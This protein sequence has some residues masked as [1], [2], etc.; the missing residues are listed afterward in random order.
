MEIKDRVDRWRRSLQTKSTLAIIITAAVL[1]EA[2]SAVQY[3]FA[4]KGIREEIERRAQTELQVKNLEIQKVMASVES[5]VGNMVWAVEERLKQSDSIPV[6]ADRLVRHNPSIVGCGIA[7]VPDYYKR[8]GRWYE[9][10]AFQVDSTKTV[11]SQ[12][13]GENHDYLQAKWFQDALAAGRGYWSDPYFDDAGAKMMLCTYSL[14]VRDEKGDIVAILGADVSL[15]WLGSVINANPIYP[16]AFNLMISREGQIMACPV[17]TLVLNKTIQELTGT[18][19][20]TTVLRINREMLE[21][22]SGQAVVKDE[23]GE[24][25]YVFYAPVEGDTGWSMAIICSDR[26]IYR[27]LRQVGFNLMLLMLLGLAL[28]M[29]ILFRAIRGFNRLQAVNAQKASMENELK[30]ASGI[31]MAMLPKIFPP[32]PDRDELDIYGSLAAAKGVGGDLFDFYIRDEKLFFCIGDVSGKGIPASLVM[33]VTRAQFRTISAHES[34]P[35][36]IVMTMND[37][38]AGENDSNMFVTLFV[39]VLDLQTGQLQYCN[40]GHEPPMLVGRGVGVLPCDP[41]IPVGVLPRWKY[42]LQVV[43]IERRSTI[44]LYTDGLDEAEDALHHQFGKEQVMGVA[45]YVLDAGKNTPMQLVTEMQDAVHAFIRGA[46][47]SDDLTLLAVQYL[48]K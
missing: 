45:R 43:Q 35:D 25:N 29:F 13:G 17:E 5:A 21:G 7:F 47:Q 9:P 24:K 30:I 40:A 48:G 28:L 20:D 31:Q 6:V 22:Q 10:Y 16:S 12:I 41:N 38:M 18:T 42:S 36:R 4:R 15:D 46:E 26:E 32:Y 1:L 14:P 19:E 23:K 27:S 33:A 2:T 34:F 37:A 39:G 8:K 11:L 44:F 3:L